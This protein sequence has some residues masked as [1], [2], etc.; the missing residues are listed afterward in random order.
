MPGKINVGILFGGKS[1]EHEI[2]VRSATNVAA[3]IDKAK[4]NVELV[5]IDKKGGWYHCAS[6]NQEIT[7]GDPLS[8]R[9][10][11]KGHFFYNL[12]RDEEILLDVIF[13]VLHGTDGEDGSIQ[14]ML[15][16]SGIPCVGSGVQGSA[17]SMDKYISKRLL[18]EAGVPVS[19]FLYANFRQRDSLNFQDIATAVG[20]PFIIK[21]A[22]LGSS[23][24]VSKISNESE[25]TKAVQNT[26][27]YDNEVIFE[28]FIEGRELECGIIGNS[29]PIATNPGEVVVSGDYAFYSYEAKYLD[30]NAAQII[31]PAKVPDQIKNSI[32]YWSVAAYQALN[33]ADYA[34]VDLFLKA[35]G[36]ILINEINTIPGFTDSSMFPMLWNDAGISYTAL[37]TKL[38]EMSLARA[39]E[40]Q[41]LETN[42]AAREYQS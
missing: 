34:R 8:L 26:F 40:K 24:G 38:I 18:K 15:T 4:Y 7:K 42:F 9:L 12:S 22:C 37:I 11:S 10:S 1:V 6:V 16:T 20:V 33:C 35:D 39:K 27:T 13:P 31:I 19:K 32:K 41:R 29:Q 14:G 17:N 2:S 3:N 21:P 36:T 5:G 30:P 23:V 25:F 28:E